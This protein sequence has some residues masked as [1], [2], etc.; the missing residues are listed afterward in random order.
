MVV[1][2]DK[3][4]GTLAAGEAAAALEA[5]LLAAAASLG[6]EVEVVRRPVADGGE[7]TLEAALAAGFEPVTL[8]APGPTG[9]PAAVAYGRRGDEALVELAHI[10]GMARLPGGWLAPLDATTLGLGVA[11]AH[12]LEGG[13]RTLVL[14]IGGSAST[15]GGAGLL[16]G[17]G[18]RLLDA[19]GRPVPPSGR[20]LGRVAQV[21]LAGLGSRWA[22]PGADGGAGG[23][24][25]EVVVACDVTNPLLGPKGA[26]AVFAPQKGASPAEVSALDGALAHWV[27]MVGHAIGPGAARAAAE[28]PGAGAAG[29]AGFAAM[30]VLGAEPVPGI[31]LVLDLVGMEAALEGAE[32]VVVGEGTLDAQTVAGKAVAGVAR[33][34]RRRRIPVAAVAGRVALGPDALAGLGI[35]R[36]VALADLAGGEAA[37]RAEPAYWLREAGRALLTGWLEE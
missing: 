13:C 35:S 26:A 23:G 37:A 17:L 12:A 6:A 16:T 14:A 32:L 1:A 33:F 3:F 30:A 9:E 28:R 15:D 20:H 19:E 10:C 8:V 24:S 4:K 34:A 22:L 25:V 5:G 31:D 7:G 18:A 11:A 36:A 27:E 21:E 29:G 2:P